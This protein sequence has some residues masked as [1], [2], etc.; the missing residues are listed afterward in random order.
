MFFK[1]LLRANYFTKYFKF[2]I[3]VFNVRSKY[4]HIVSV[5]SWKLLYKFL[6]PIQFLVSGIMTL[7]KYS[8]FTV[9]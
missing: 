1:C 8:F 9:I 5:F 4:L 6:S 7:K 3:Y 2:I